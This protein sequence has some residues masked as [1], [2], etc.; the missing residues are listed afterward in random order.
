M[1]NSTNYIG[2]WLEKMNGDTSYIFK[3]SSWAS[4][5]VDFNH[6]SNKSEEEVLISADNLPFRSASD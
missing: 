5:A 3:A 2:S 4:K 6:F 1:D